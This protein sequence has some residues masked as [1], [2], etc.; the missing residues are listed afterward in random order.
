VITALDQSGQ[1]HLADLKQE[2]LFMAA[3]DEFRQLM[4][5]SQ[6]NRLLK[7]L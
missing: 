1:H 5:K 4:E 7:E 6:H 2:Q 3:I